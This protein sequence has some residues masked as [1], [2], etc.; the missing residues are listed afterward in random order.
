MSSPR[1]KKHIEEFVREF[2]S[3]QGSDGQPALGRERDIRPRRTRWRRRWAPN[4][5]ARCSAEFGPLES[6]YAFAS[7]R[8]L[9]SAAPRAGSA[10]G[11]W[12]DLRRDKKEEER[13][14][15]ARAMRA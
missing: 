3:D 8:K 11:R 1:F 2:V 13:E 10:R 6:A 9:R 7:G 5:Y 14:Q 4:Q 12:R 15:T